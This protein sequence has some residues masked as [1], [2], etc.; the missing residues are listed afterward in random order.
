MDAVMGVLSVFSSMSKQALES[1]K[2]RADIKVILL[3]PAKLYEGRRERAEST[4]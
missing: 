1:A 4:M 2:I 3:G